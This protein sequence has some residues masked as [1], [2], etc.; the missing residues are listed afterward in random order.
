MGQSVKSD[1]STYLANKHLE[2]MTEETDYKKV[3][4]MYS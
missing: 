4:Q 3:E 1:K 2:S